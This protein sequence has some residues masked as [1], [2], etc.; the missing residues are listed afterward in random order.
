MKKNYLKVMIFIAGNLLITLPVSSI[1]NALKIKISDSLYSDEAVVRFLPNATSNFDSGYDAWKLFGSNP[2]VPAIFTNIDS[3]SHLSINALSAFAKETD[4]DL[5]LSIKVSYSK[6]YTIKSIETGTFS[7]GVSI[8][9]EDK[10]TGMIY[11]FRNGSSLNIYLFANSIAT[12]GRFILHFS[13]PTN[14]ELTNVTCTGLS[15][16]KIKITKP[17]NNN[18]DYQLKDNSG[19]IIHSGSGVNETATI[20]GLEVGS[21]SVETSSSTTFSDTNIFTILQPNVIIANYE[22]DSAGILIAPFVPIV[23]HNI[24]SGAIS[25]TWDFGDGSAIS[26]Q[27]SPTHQYSAEGVYTVTLTAANEN[28]EISY[29]NTIIVSPSLATIIASLSKNKIFVSAYQQNE[30]LIINSQTEIETKM[31]I[32]V[33]DA[34]GENV[35]FSSSDDSKNVSRSITLPASGT[36]FISV[37]TDTNRVNK[38]IAYIK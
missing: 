20:T 19:T 26:N 8:M 36:Y 37:F 22:V 2:S 17:G 31:D 27:F 33:F 4:F 5:E 10:I 12:A 16:G 21:Y 35:Y 7:N 15:N 18:W 32:S 30:M 13:P 24:S 25:Y 23:F 6:F 9:L 14:F 3:Q 28:C 1:T 34:L 29:S 38:I 11:P